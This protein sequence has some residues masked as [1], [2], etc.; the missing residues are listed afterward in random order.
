MTAA[1]GSKQTMVARPPAIVL[2]YGSHKNKL[3]GR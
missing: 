1:G 2:N 3:Q